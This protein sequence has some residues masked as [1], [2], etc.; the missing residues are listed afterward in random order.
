MSRV[1][2]SVVVLV[3]AG[4]VAG[5]AQQTLQPNASI[6]RKFG[7]KEKHEFVIPGAGN[8]RSIYIGS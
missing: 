1:V 5:L 4:A 7:P 8:Q 2:A 6:E 3:L